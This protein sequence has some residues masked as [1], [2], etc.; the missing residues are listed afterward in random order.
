VSAALSALK[1][2]PL[3]AHA[4]SEDL[5]G[6]VSTF[7]RA[8]ELA[9]EDFHRGEHLATVARACEALALAEGSAAARLPVVVLLASALARLDRHLEAVAACD[10]GLRFFPWASGDA[11]QTREQER[12]LLRRAGCFLILGQPA[13]ALSDYRSATKLNPRSSQAAAGVQQAWNAL[14]SAHAQDSLYDVLG[15]CRDASDEELKR[16]YRKLALRWHPDKH[17]QSD[18]A[19]QAEADA[20]FKQLQD[21]W[22]LL[23]VAETRAAYD[24][25]LRQQDG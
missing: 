17:A 18:G 16:A 15:V 1:D 10:L 19:V 3:A 25:E 23:S 11:Q 6:V 13:Q 7:Q 9:Q 8:H 12:L 20:R 22:A 24:A 21:A 4:P 5:H 2:P 14:K